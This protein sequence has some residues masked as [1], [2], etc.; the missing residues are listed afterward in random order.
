MLI[1]LIWI[2]ILSR[3]YTCVRVWK[4][5]W[6]ESNQRILRNGSYK[7]NCA[8]GQ[9]FRCGYACFC[10]QS[11]SNR[12]NRIQMLQTQTVAPELVEFLKFVM[13][14]EVFSNFLLVWGT[15]L[16]LQI[17]HRHSVDLDFF[18]NVEIEPELFRQEISKYGEFHILK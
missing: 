14:S 5:E 18:G 7:R 3:W 15:S 2:S 10:V 8:Y 6:L 11:F 12:Q 16:A 4:L 1:L 9:K 13:H 17:G